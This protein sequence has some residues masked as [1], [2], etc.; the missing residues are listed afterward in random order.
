MDPVYATPLDMWHFALPPDTLFKDRGVEPGAW[1]TPVKTG[2]GTGEMQLALDSNPR[3]NFD[4][5]VRCV[6]AGELNVYGIVNPGPVPN[7]I[8]SLDA[9]LT[10]SPVLTPKDIGCLDWQKGGFTVEFNNGVAPVSFVIGDEWSFSTN[11]SPDIMRFLS[12][13]SRFIDGKIKNT[14]CTPLVSWGDDVVLMTCQ[15]AR[16]FL[17]QRRGLDKNQDFKVYRP[18]DAFAWLEDTGKGYNQA[19]V[20]ESGDGFVFANWSVA[21]PPFKTRWRF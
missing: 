16:W 18:V 15:I 17:I 20:K 9:G 6:S 13:A 8:I 11:P 5:L 4:V 1:T 10:F 3:S 7:F 12:A 2:V 21:R 19:T 14:Y